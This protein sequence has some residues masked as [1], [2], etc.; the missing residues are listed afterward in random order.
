[1]GVIMSVIVTN[2]VSVRSRLTAS[3]NLIIIFLFLEKRIVSIYALNNIFIFF[4]WCFCSTFTGPGVHRSFLVLLLTVLL[5][6]CLVFVGDVILVLFAISSLNFSFYCYYPSSSR[7]T[8][9]SSLSSLSSSSSSL[10]SVFLFLLLLHLFFNLF[11]LFYLFLIF[12]VVI[13]TSFS[14]SLFTSSP[15]SSSSSSS[16]S[17]SPS[18]SPSPSTTSSSSSISSSSSTSSISCSCSSYCSSTAMAFP[19]T[20]HLLCQAK[21]VEMHDFRNKQIERLSDSDSYTVSST[22][23]DNKSCFLSLSV[24]LIT[25]NVNI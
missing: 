15:S 19:H 7:S 6:L 8:S 17:L 2:A 9:S 4:Y 3:T 14:N 23:C 21:S 22:N 5:V 11:F 10:S 20:C 13:I 18:F 25:R 24:R 1:M 16:S 12:I